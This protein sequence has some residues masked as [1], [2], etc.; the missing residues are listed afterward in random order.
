MTD[1]TRVLKQVELFY[2]LNDLQLDALA[3]IAQR[4]DYL[5]GAP[6]LEQ[7]QLGS[8]MYIIADGQ[9]EIVRVNADG[10]A[11]TAIF[12][13]V[14]Q[15]FGELALLDFG[16]RSAS[17][18]ADEDPTTLYRL[19]RDAVNTLCQADTALGYVLMHNLARDLA[20]KLRHGG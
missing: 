12:L 4:E 3:G 19:D 15:V 2:G 16:A 6:I 7:G 8:S 11:R 10:G 9:V 20:F 14:G 5:L 18:L 13:G 17:V 1:L